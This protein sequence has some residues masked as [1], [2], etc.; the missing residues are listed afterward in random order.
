MKKPNYEDKQSK[1]P[2]PHAK[3][4]I[5]KDSKVNQ[6]PKKGVDKSTASKEE[7]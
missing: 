7:E 2:I 6:G 5:D 4:L 1:H 3:G